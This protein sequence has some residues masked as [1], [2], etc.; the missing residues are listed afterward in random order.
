MKKRRKRKQ[1]LRRW[2]ERASRNVEKLRAETVTTR[3]LE[4][5]DVRAGVL[6]RILREE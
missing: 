3:V 1:T 6:G 2:L 4:Q 5:E